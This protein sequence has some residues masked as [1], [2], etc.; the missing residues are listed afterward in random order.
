MKTLRM[1]GMVLFAV[2]MCVNF[3]SCSNEEITPDN[4]NQEK[5]ITVGL[6]CVG[7]Y[8]EIKD[9]PLSRA[10]GDAYEIQVYTVGEGAYAHGKFSSLDGLTI[11]LFKHKKYRFK[12]AVTVGDSGYD[13]QFEY[14]STD[15]FN[16][17]KVLIPYEAEGI[18]ASA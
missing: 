9:S 17:M 2:L 16:G 5:Y 18:K 8:L 7:E 6:D 12:I 13:T 14:S 10:G 3:A 11:K 15:H 1:F 4:P